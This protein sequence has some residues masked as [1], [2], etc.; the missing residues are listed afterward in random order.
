MAYTLYFEHRIYSQRLLN[1]FLQKN[2]T[3]SSDSLSEVAGSTPVQSM[4]NL[5]MKI[6]SEIDLS[7]VLQLSPFHYVSFHIGSL[8]SEDGLWPVA[9]EAGYRHGSTPK[10]KYKNQIQH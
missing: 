2:I 9:A 8:S 1:L 4:G 10:R 7:R 6:G 5:C 3:Y